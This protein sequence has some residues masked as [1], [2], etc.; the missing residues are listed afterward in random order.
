MGTCR[1]GCA[2]EVLPRSAIVYRANP[3]YDDG[4]DCE[5]LHGGR[6]KEARLVSTLPV[7]HKARASNLSASAGWEK[8][9]EH[10]PATGEQIT[11]PVR[12]GQLRSQ[13]KSK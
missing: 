11:F 2:E 5:S 9:E 1:T 8:L 12:T 10:L 13:E 4:I 7:G 3:A 6:I